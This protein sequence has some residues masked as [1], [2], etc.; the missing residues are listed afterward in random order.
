MNRN[1]WTLMYQENLRTS[2]TGLSANWTLKEQYASYYTDVK[3]RN[4]GEFVWALG[5]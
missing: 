4:L 2:E 5:R 1:S 3:M